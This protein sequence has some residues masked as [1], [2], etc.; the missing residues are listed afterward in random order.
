[1]YIDANLL[2]SKLLGLDVD[3]LSD[4]RYDRGYAD[5]FNAVQ[6]I[7]SDCIERTNRETIL[8]GTPSKDEAR[9]ILRNCGILDENG[10]IMPAYK[11]IVVRRSDADDV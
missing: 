10:E 8:V 9:Q 6:K 11:G 2:K 4:D 3:F 7:I 5:C 1:M